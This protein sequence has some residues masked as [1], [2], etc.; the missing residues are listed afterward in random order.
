MKQTLLNSSYFWHQGT[1]IVFPV[2][3]FLHCETSTP[4]CILNFINI[5][6]IVF[7][8]FYCKIRPLQI[9]YPFIIFIRLTALLEYLN[10]AI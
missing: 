2:S 9:N 4:D 3:N 6:L 1:T 10:L 7:N 8:A 5:A